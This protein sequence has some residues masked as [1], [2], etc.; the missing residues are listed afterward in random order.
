MEILI[1]I[2]ILCPTIHLFSDDV[3]C[4]VAEFELGCASSFID[5]R[6]FFFVVHWMMARGDNPFMDELPLTIVVRLQE[7]YLARGV[8]KGNRRMDGT[9]NSPANKRRRTATE[10]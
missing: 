4:C 1:I 7:A 5:A 2:L 9:P 10:R 3:V 8:H 6:V